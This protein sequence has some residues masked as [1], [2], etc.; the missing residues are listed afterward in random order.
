MAVSA[1]RIVRGV[2]RLSYNVS[3]ADLLKSEHPL[4]NPFLVFCGAKAP[5]KRQA[6]RFLQK[7]P[8]Y[9][10]IKAG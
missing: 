5:S 7:F 6:V 2:G 10:E 9:R 1:K 8:Q 4:H 3:A